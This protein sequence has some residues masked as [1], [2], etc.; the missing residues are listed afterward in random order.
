M[1]R[2]LEVKGL[3]NRVD[4]A[5]EFNEDLNII[6]GRN[7]SGKTTLLKLIWYVISGNIERIPPEIPF[8]FVSIE[9]DSFSLS[10]QIQSD[11]GELHYE[12]ANEGKRDTYFEIP[13]QGAD[14]ELIDE[15]NIRIVSMTNSSLFFP[16]FRRVEGGF[17][18][19]SRYIPDDNSVMYQPD[20]LRRR[21][22]DRATE[23]LQEAMARISTEVS[24]YDHKFIASISTHDIVELLTEKYADVSEKTNEL[25]AKLS[26]DITQKIS[27]RK[28]SD[29]PNPILD[30]IQK[31]VEEDNKEKDLLLRPFSVLGE[32]IRDIFQYSGIRLTAARITLGEVKEAIESDKLSAGEKQ[33]LSFLCYNTFSENAAIFIDEPELSL[34]VD[35]QRLLLPT[36]LEQETGNQFFIATHSPFIYAKYPDKEILLGED[37]GGD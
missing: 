17:A 5:M 13:L 18:R 9:T 15:L 33:M 12:F 29:D 26:G 30:S 24:V 27:G 37:R 10:I 36:L 20:Q 4:A 6:T 32:R 34:H 23:L 21:F 11:K 16:T 19:F 22:R 14:C 25:H 1:I 35:W 28:P 8:Q 2:K 3:N 31:R 7:G